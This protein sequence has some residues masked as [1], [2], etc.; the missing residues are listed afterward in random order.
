MTG[1][2][3]SVSSGWPGTVGG[4]GRRAATASGSAEPGLVVVGGSMGDVGAG[5]VETGPEPSGGRADV[6]LWPCG[7]GGMVPPNSGHSDWKLHHPHNRLGFGRKS[8]SR[9]ARST[10]SDSATNV[11]SNRSN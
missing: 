2:G 3:S 9:F 7:Y 1:S 8:R 11:R 6:A 5:T 10:A 4:P